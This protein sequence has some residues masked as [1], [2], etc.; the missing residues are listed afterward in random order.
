MCRSSRKLYFSDL[1]D[2]EKYRYPDKAMGYKAAQTAKP[3]GVEFGAVGAGKGA[4]VG[5]ILGYRRRARAE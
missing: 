1:N 4:T 3:D 5:K 2:P